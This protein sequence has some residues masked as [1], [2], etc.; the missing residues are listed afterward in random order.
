MKLPNLEFIRSTLGSKV[1]EAFKAVQDQASSTE[2]Q[3]NLNPTGPPAPPPAINSL[4]MSTGPGGEMQA[5]ITDTSM[6]SRGVKY[7]LEHADNAQFNNPH[8]ID[9]GAS[10][11]WSGHLGNQTLYWRAYSSYEASGASPAVYHGS[12][13]APLP[14]TGGT[15]GVRS[16]SQG[17]GTGAP[18]Q[19]LHGPGPIP[20]RIPDAGFD[21]KSQGNVGTGN[22]SNPG[23]NSGAT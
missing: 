21:W 15:A 16:Q 1:Y 13:V 18:G 22:S 3:A 9:L 4:R 6:V 10:R 17:A 23:S 19:G 14:V 5:E 8:H 2:Q 11:N 7:W 20:A 12:A